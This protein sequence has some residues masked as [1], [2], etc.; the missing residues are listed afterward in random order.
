ME[1]KRY[2]QLSVEERIE[3]YRLHADGKS[4][5]FIAKEIG[6]DAGTISRELRRNS[7]PTGHD[8]D[9]SYDPTRAER[10]AR[11]RRHRA[12]GNRLDHDP[13][14]AAKVRNG[15]IQGRLSPEQIA[16][17]LAVLAG[18]QV[19][20]YETIY[21]Y[22]YRQWH[23]R[24]DPLYRALPEGRVRRR[25]H[26]P[27]LS[28]LC[29]IQHRV[30][31]HD[32]PV[33]VLGRQTRGHWEADLIQFKTYGQSLVLHERRSRFTLLLPQARKTAK[34]VA[35]T[36][37]SFF[38]RLPVSMRQSVTFDNGSEF[39]EHHRLHKTLGLQTYFCDPHA[40]WQKGGVEHAIKR[41]RRDL[42]RATDPSSLSQN[43]LQI[44]SNRH[45]LTPR[46]CLGFKTPV[47]VF[48]DIKP[49]ALTS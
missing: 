6:R 17:R 26:R 18:H 37:Q 16:G 9:K 14:L 34:E 27:R 23:I 42:P 47:E 5:R 11:T 10:R 25:S 4:C 2:K 12:R 49:V 20:S 29:A 24:K 1:E 33:V 48:F 21:R 30:S 28:N 46:K 38:T 44:I 43:C 8:L 45:N 22:V 15:L 36:L 35:D 7:R 31:I 32:R 19:I 3:I 40:P 13:D 41:F 39:Y